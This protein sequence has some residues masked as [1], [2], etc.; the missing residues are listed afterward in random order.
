M[1]QPKKTWRRGRKKTNRERHSIMVSPECWAH[2]GPPNW[3]SRK[4][5]S[6]AA[7]D[8]KLPPDEDRFWGS[9]LPDMIQI[10]KGVYILAD[11]HPEYGKVNLAREQRTKTLIDEK[12]E[13]D[14]GHQEDPGP[15]VDMDVPV[16]HDE[17][18]KSKRTAPAGQ[19]SP[20]WS[21]AK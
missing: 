21:K 19:M 3:K 11:T 17:R 13:A 8:A 16:L 7:L 12:R 14:P 10:A 20:L 18:P 4:I 1:E 6:M 5:E 9:D 2:L 15:A